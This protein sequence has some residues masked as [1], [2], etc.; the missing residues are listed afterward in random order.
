MKIII[1]DDHVLFRE[2][3]EEYLKRYWPESSA[4][5]VADFYS[6]YDLLQQGEKPDLIVLDY[7]MAGMEEGKGFYQVREEFPNQRVAI[8]SGVAERYQVRTV[9]E[10]GAVGY[11]PKTL[12]GKDFIAGLKKVTEGE[13][14]IPVGQSSLAI[15]ESYIAKNS[16]QDS[17]DLSVVTADDIGLSK[18]ESDVLMCLLSGLSNKEIAHRLS[19]E[20]VTVK[21]HISKIS[22]KMDVKTRTQIV[23]KARDLGVKDMGLVDE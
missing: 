20:E 2:S 21:M 11:F 17:E 7:N 14:Y 15:K 12:S 9:V 22:K 6:V 8:M 19:I 5:F 1:A 4:I 23:L 13:T 10:H 16:G 18:R 3:L